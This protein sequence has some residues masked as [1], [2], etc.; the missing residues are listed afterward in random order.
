VLNSGRRWTAYL[1]VAVGITV[2]I[3]WY[4]S[5]FEECVETDTGGCLQDSAAVIVTVVV[6]GLVMPVVMFFG[7]MFARGR[8][9][10]DAA[11]TKTPA[12]QRGRPDER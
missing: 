1:L 6:L 11:E 9:K 8:R 12:H 10:R 5:T 7:E 2:A 3:G 4:F